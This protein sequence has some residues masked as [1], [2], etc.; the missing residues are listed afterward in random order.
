MTNVILVAK[1]GYNVLTETSTDNFNYRSD[2]DTLKY[3]TT[4]EIVVDVD[5]ANYYH[6]VAGS[7]PIFP[8]TY[9]HRKVETVAHGLGY[10]P[11]FA[12]YFI[13]GA[14][15]GKDIQVP[16]LFGD[17]IY[18]ASVSAYAD[19]TNISFLVQFVNDSNSGTTNVTFRYRIF[20]NDLGL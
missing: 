8:T 1:T 3:E 15:T 9:Y 20:K 7:P 4:G 19:S 11:Y 6:T 12:A 18:T 10:T 17:F 13:D 14:G 5:K 16:Y 2:Y